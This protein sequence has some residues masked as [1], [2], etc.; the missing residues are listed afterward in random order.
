MLKIDPYQNN[1]EQYDKWFEK[2]PDVY[3]AELRAVRS[4]LPP[5][6]RGCIEIGVGTGRFAAPLGIKIG[7]EPSESMRKISQKRGIKVLGGVA[8]KLPLKDSAVEVV[9]MVTVICFVSDIDKTFKESFRVLSEGGNIVVAMIDRNSPMG[10]IYLTRKHNSL[11]YKQAIFYSVDE[12]I[13][14][15]RQTGFDDFEF[16]QT[17]FHNIS[18]INE[19]EIIRTGYGE[20]LFAVIRGK[21]NDSEANG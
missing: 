3:D 14:I 2:N 1:A 17:V 13:K 15:M 5:I 8:E 18:E 21:K 11:F 20:G 6:S 12:V 16:R 19:N 7:I 9:L 4:L 10:Q